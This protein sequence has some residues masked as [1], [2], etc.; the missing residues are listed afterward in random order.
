MVCSPRHPC[1]LSSHARPSV[2]YVA[3]SSCHPPS[4]K[5]KESGTAL[6]ETRRG[7]K[8]KRGKNKETRGR[9]A[10]LEP[11]RDRQ[12]DPP[13]TPRHRESTRTGCV[14]RGDILGRVSRYRV[15]TCRW[16]SS[17]QLQLAFVR[18]A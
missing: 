11:N 4:L 3:L 8:E 15:L 17:L 5:D 13:S 2:S 12:V 10:S 16:M 6:A 7:V 1:W 14:R 18:S 9:K